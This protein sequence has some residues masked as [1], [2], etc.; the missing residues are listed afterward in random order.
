MIRD[1]S[2]TGPNPA[3][4]LPLYRSRGGDKEKLG[5]AIHWLTKACEQLLK[6][7]GLGFD[8]RKDLLSNLKGLF[9]CELCMENAV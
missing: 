1:I 8:P 5:R 6:A 9:S 2:S 4:A 3:V 7:R